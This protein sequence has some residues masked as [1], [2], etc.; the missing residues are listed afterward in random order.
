MIVKKEIHLSNSKE[1]ITTKQSITSPAQQ[2]YS[3]RTHST[4][5]QTTILVISQIS[6]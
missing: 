1:I 4:N 2:T 6:K 5:S 3:P